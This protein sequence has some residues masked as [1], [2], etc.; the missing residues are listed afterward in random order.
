MISLIWHSLS[1]R[2]LFLTLVFV[3]LAE[4][5]IFVPSVARFREDFLHERLEKG[6]IAALAAMEARG[7]MPSTE[8]Q[9]AVLKKAE[10]YSVVMDRN[11]R[12]EPILMTPLPGMVA[13]TYDL[14]QAGPLTLMGD[15]VTALFRTEP[16]FI[17]VRGR[18]PAGGGAL[19]EVVLEESGLR[20]AMRAYGLRIFLISL[21]LSVL[22]AAMVFLSVNAFV[23]APM[24]RVI[25]GVIRFREDPEDASRVL[26]PSGARGEIGQAER[27]LALTQTE[28]VNALKQK[29]R[30]AA[31]GEAVAKI[32]HDLRNILATAH[33]LADRLEASKDPMVG[34]VGPKLLASLD[35]ATRLCQQTLAYG[36]AEESPPDLRPIRVG[37]LAE[38]VGAALGLMGETAPN[39]IR[40]ENRTAPDLMIEADA[41]QIFR[42]LLNLA[43]NAHQALESA[44]EGGCIAVEARIEEGRALI[45]VVDDGPGLPEKARENLFKAFKGSVRRGGSGLGLAIAAELARGHGGALS[46]VE[47]SERG[48][49]FRLILP[50]AGLDAAAPPQKTLLPGAAE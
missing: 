28:V 43:R 32:N 46:L 3:M 7:G 26:R 2:L 21:V 13:A 22:T 5:L 20:A 38:E 29:S 1:G 14:Q 36:K 35:R 16:R 6:Q 50:R 18:P 39:D 25:D 44:G 31:L 17:R 30:L 23:L 12:R 10:V 41:D 34:V 8:L 37:D 15:A 49:R 24:R 47:T 11:G 45:D 33:L 9:R 19:V 42:A 48:A 27:E 40:F 4:V